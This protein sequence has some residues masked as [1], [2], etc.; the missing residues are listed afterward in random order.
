M[1]SFWD[2]PTALQNIFVQKFWEIAAFSDVDEDVDDNVERRNG[3]FFSSKIEEAV[4]VLATQMWCEFYCFL[5][6]FTSLNLSDSQVK[7][8]TWLAA[9]DA[10][11]GAPAELAAAAV[12]AA[13]RWQS[14]VG[15]AT[16]RLQYGWRQDSAL[17][18]RIIFVR[19]K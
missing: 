9:A 7:G 4:V 11:L 1:M 10:E 8:M 5:A 18:E 19:I 14:S 3:V 6:I 17:L 2:Y 16:G 13:P 12:V 15:E